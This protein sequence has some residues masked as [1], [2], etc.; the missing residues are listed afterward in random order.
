[1]EKEKMYLEPLQNMANVFGGVVHIKKQ[2]DQRKTKPT[3]F[4][5]VGTETISPVLKFDEMNA[6]LLGYI[7][8]YKKLNEKV[9]TFQELKRSVNIVR[10]FVEVTEELYFEA[11]GAVPPNYLKNGTWQMG[12]EY[13]NGLFYTFG[14]KDGKYY[15]CLCNANY[16]INNF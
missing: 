16:A 12:E 3:F 15:G 7:R 9:N 11:L 8:A 4:C 14:E 5:N 13:S 2:Y 10:G 6:F 1:M